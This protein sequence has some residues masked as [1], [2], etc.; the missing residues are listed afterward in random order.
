MS[1]KSKTLNMIYSSFKKKPA[2]VSKIR[3]IHLLI[4]KHNIKHLIREGFGRV[5][6]LDIWRVAER[7]FGESDL[8]EDFLDRIVLSVGDPLIILSPAEYLIKYRDELA[9]ARSL[10]TDTGGAT[11]RSYGFDPIV[12]ISSSL[13][14]STYVMRSSD[15]DVSIFRV[16]EYNKIYDLEISKRYSE[17]LNILSEAFEIYGLYKHSDAVKILMRE[18]G[19]DRVEAQKILRDL[20]EQGLIRIDKGGYIAINP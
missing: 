10:Y 15:G 1:E 5:Y 19:L 6:I 17:V 8:F 2:F 3:R 4:L 20:Y 18:L 13:R 12:T 16:D 7:S 9:Q 11:I 14:P